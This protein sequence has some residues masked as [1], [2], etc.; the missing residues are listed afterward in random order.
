MQNVRTRILAPYV[1]C[2]FSSVGNSISIIN[3]FVYSL[4]MTTALRWSPGNSK[5]LEN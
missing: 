5:N 1:F 2:S 3:N 4:Q